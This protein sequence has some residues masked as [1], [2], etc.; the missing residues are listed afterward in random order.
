MK[1]QPIRIAQIMGNMNGGGVESVVMNYFRHINRERFQFDFIVNEGSSLIPKEEIE[2]LGGKVFMIPSYT[3]QLS[4]QREL[5]KLLETEKWDIVHS[6]VNALSVLPLHAA[7]RA[8]VPVRIAHS[9]NT[10]GTGEHIRNL[11][12]NILRLFSNM[13]PTHRFACS[14]HA[15]EWLF[16]TKTPFEIIYNAIDLDGYSFNPSLRQSTREQL[17]IADNQLVIGHIGRFMPQKNHVFLLKIFSQF[18]EKRDDCILVCVGDG[19]LLDE[20]KQLSEQLGIS[21]KVKF[22]GYRNDTISLYQAF[23]VFVLPSLYEGLGLVGIEAQRTGLPC[24]FSEDVPREVEMSDSSRF[25]SL[26]NAAAWV[27]ALDDIEIGARG[28]ADDERFIRYDIVAASRLLADR[29]GEML[30]GIRD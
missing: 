1:K 16:G 28:Q 29:Y 2:A 21:D 8:N 17:G 5:R 13:Y 12:K 22:L 3:H 14:K 24:L 30:N 20:M 26:D 4:Y 19:E 15:G 27:E 6:H 10:A 7:K 25:I 23:D 9:H 11:A 18:C